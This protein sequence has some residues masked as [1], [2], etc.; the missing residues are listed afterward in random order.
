[1]TESIRRE[2]TLAAPPARVWRALTDSAE[3][4]EWMYPNDFEPE[5][6][7]VL[8]LDD[9]LTGDVPGRQTGYPPQRVDPGLRSSL[10]PDGLPDAGR[11]GIPDGMRF[12]LPVLLAARLG[13]VMRVILGA[14]ND[15]VLRTRTQEI[16]DIDRKRRESAFV[17]ARVRSVDP[18]P[19]GV[20]DRPEHEENALSA[21]S[22]GNLD[23]APVPT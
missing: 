1:M 19:R 3:I 4:A 21:L 16:G 22:R 11:S 9:D 6:F 7:P 14:E 5:V 8:P 15:F 12:E 2:V 10:Q 13:Q 20:I 18:H 17:T 23:G